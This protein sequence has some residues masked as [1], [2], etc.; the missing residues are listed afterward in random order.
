MGAKSEDFWE[1]FIV[2]LGHL[3]VLCRGT[4]GAHA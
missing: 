4:R 2:Q 3:D 1:Y